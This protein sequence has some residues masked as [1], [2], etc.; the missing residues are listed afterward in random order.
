M[1]SSNH[2]DHAR[3]IQ[4]IYVEPL[5]SELSKI[6]YIFLLAFEEKFFDMDSFNQKKK[7]RKEKKKEKK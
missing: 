2:K 5:A 6:K 7:K 4:S 1:C 3:E